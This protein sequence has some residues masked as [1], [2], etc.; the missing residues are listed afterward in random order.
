MRGIG[1]FHPI[2]AIRN[3]FMSI[4]DNARA[5]P[6]QTI[7]RVGVGL[8]NPAAGAALGRGF[9]AYNDH[10]FNTAASGLNDR[11][12]ASGNRAAASAMDKP[13]NGPLGNV[14]TGRGSDNSALASA[15]Q[16][17]N[18]GSSPGYSQPNT[19][20]MSQLFGAGP[21]S[22]SQFVNGLL[23]GI[24]VSGG[25]QQA[26]QA[27]M[28]TPQAGGNL[29]LGLSSGGGNMGGGQRFGN[30]YGYSGAGGGSGAGSWAGGGGMRT[31]WV[32]PPT[33]GGGIARGRGKENGIMPV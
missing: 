29:G 4:I 28:N 15:L 10:S 13:L 7:A 24:P 31:I 1:D 8:A 19:W 30:S 25:R 33:G 27:F 12:V 23:N 32:N 3:R 26:Q 18:V 14:P 16:G 9:N 22:S 6:F 5:H 17:V 21:T 11:T 2:D 20:N